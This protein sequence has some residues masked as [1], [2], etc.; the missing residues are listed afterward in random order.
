[1]AGGDFAPFRA[2]MQAAGLS[3]AAI[4]AFEFSYESLVSGETGM[5]GETTITPADNLPYLEGKDDSIRASIK[6][7]PELLKET[8]VL[9]LNGGLG[10]S[11]GLDKAKS[12]LNVK[13][14]DTF[15]D[16]MAKQVT[17][18]RA[19]HQSNVRFVLMN[20]FSTSNDTLDYLQKYPELVEDENLELLQNKVP[21]VDAKTLEPATYET[22]PSKEWCP[23]GHGDLYPSLAGSGKLEKLVAQGV[24]YMFVS[25]SD[26]LGATLDLDLLTYFAQSGKPFLMEC[27]E[28]TENDKK[29]GHL[30]Q[31]N[32]DGRL[33]LRESAQCESDDE[34]H[35]QN[36]NKH[37]YFNTNNLWIRLDKLA[38]E[39]EKQG[40]V[41]RLPMIKNS[42]TVDPKD[43]SSTP[44]FQLETAMGAAIECFD[45]AGAVCVPRTRFAPVKKCDDLLLLRSDAYV[46]TEDYRPVLAPERE[47]VAPIVSLDGKTF[48]LVQQL[49]AALRGNVPSLIKCDRLKIS[50]KVGFAPGVVFE[51]SV[52]V[53]NNSSE[54]KT[55][56][57]GVYKDTTLDLTEQK[58]LGKFKVT[59]V[60]TSPIEGQKPGTSGLRKKTKTFMDGHYLHNFVQSVFDALPTKDVQG[61]TLVVSGDG[62]YFNKEAIQIIVKI[63]VAA[64]V[65]R[66]WIGKDGLL[67]TPAVS[68][69][70]RE[71]EGG[72]VAFGAFILSASHNPG[73][74]DED[75]GIKYNCENGGPAP[76]KVT[77]EIFNNTKVI[78]TINIAQD[79]PAVDTTK[80]GKTTVVSDD[81][82]RKVEIEV[83]DSAED[84]VALL[85]KIFDFNAIKQLLA[86]DDFSLV[87]DAMWGVQGPYAHRVFVEELGAPES[88]II[89]GTPKEDFNCGHADPNLT[90]A[91]EL[92]KIMGVDNKGLP[93]F[94]QDQEPPSFGV[95]WDGDADRNMILGS[96]FFVTPSDSLAI[97]AA[98]ANVIPFFAKKGGLRGV[99]R[100]MPTSGAVDLVAKKLGVALFE[101]PT[102]WK[103]FGNLM[104]SGEVYGKEDYTPFICGEESFGTGSNHIREKD[105]MW[106]ALAW[107]S[108]LAAKQTEGAPLVTVEDIVRA[109]WKEFGRNYYCRY[110]Y[111]NVEKPGADAMFAAMSNFEEAV[112]K[113]INGFKIKTA[114]QFA[115][116]D[117]VDGS[118]SKNQGV[119][120]IFEDGSRVIFRLSGTG[121]AGATIR[122]YIEKYESPSGNLDQDA[123]TALAPL[124]DVGLQLSNL[125]KF[126]GRTAPTVI[127]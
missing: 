23:P 92:I 18:L 47:N 19:Q 12:L 44:V 38:E 74:P 86:R 96:R 63:A 58:G 121:V 102:G 3:E 26:N 77:D 9:K 71:R 68:A 91:K 76:E 67:S 80:V 40:G 84:H 57:P 15:L 32:A 115:Y 11:M 90:Y 82:S 64:G 112:G 73:G 21:K 78:S 98:N 89:N 28:R 56:L 123:A 100:S 104:D 106:A 55:I 127:T 105:G 41:I 126:T 5:I 59:A 54:E 97:I 125:V 1:M 72:S 83:F 110:D 114:D 62:R 107:L 88:S 30:A 95:A 103:F 75:F 37:R 49:E 2:K 69:V 79:F 93:V 8:V 35:F 39:L 13:G 36:I 22:N 34:V 124:I 25:N 81:G 70:V 61:G 66:F 42:K 109:H 94:G 29:G 17:E 16:I 65:E 52:T 20:S 31:R 10:T 101:V 119:R 46:I 33:I 6:A 45:G 117:P 116:H 50:G 43:S 111:E 51:G 85:K 48:K 24:K 7:D 99:A 122:M 108:I 120:F 4:K 87:G 118:V 60:K 113:E 14:D 53:V 27:C